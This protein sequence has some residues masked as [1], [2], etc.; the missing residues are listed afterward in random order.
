[1]RISKDARVMGGA[2]GLLLSFLL[3]ALP[4]PSARLCVPL[5]SWRDLKAPHQ[6]WPYGN[7]AIYYSFDLDDGSHAHLVVVNY[8]SPKWRIRPALALPTT[9]STSETAIREKASAAI[10][11]GYFNLKEGGASTSFVTIGGAMV[12]DPRTNKLLIENPKLQPFLPQIFNRTEVRFLQPTAIQFAKHNDPLPPNTKL[13]SAIQ[14]GPRLLPASDAAEEAFIRKEV[15]GSTTDAI[16]TKRPAARTAF[17][18]TPDGYAMF[19]TVAGKGQ[20]PESSGVTL[21][22]LST[23]LKH[24]GCSDAINFDGG[25]STTMYVRLGTIGQS[26]DHIP[27]GSTVCGK[28]PET[29]VKSILMLEYIQPILKRK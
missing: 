7:G 28:N 6:V 17:G 11:G 1:M 9:A 25:A 26:T 23:V 10:N 21:D 8:R 19:L 12:A 4:A 29:R 13:V 22:Q 15:D 16:G 18:I 2:F 27:P 14:A 3:W 24:L 20:D 5:Q